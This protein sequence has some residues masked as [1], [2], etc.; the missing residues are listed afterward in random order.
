MLY[1]K[2]IHT[3]RLQAGVLYSIF[4]R[5]A[6][7]PGF[8]RMETQAIVDTGKLSESVSDLREVVRVAFD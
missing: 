2:I 4:M 5:S 3:C 6:E 7:M 1:F 8:Y